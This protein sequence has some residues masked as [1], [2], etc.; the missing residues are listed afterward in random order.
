MDDLRSL[1]TLTIEE[2]MYRSSV[3][4]AGLSNTAQGD[5]AYV[6]LV[7]DSS[8]IPLVMQAIEQNDRQAQSLLGVKLTLLQNVLVIHAP[9]YSGVTL[10]R[11]AKTLQPYGSFDIA[12]KILAELSKYE[13]LHP[14]VFIQLLTPAKIY[15]DSRDMPHFQ[16]WIDELQLFETLDSTALIDLRNQRLAE[17]ML[18]AFSDDF[19]PKQIQDFALAI[20]NGAYESMLDLL[21]GL[22]AYRNAYYDSDSERRGEHIIKLV[23]KKLQRHMLLIALIV[24]G[25]AYGYYWFFYSATSVND[26]VL[27]SRIGDVQF[28]LQP[29]VPGT[30]KE[31]DTYLLDFQTPPETIQVEQDSSPIQ[32]NEVQDTHNEKT[33]SVLISPGDTLY[34]ICEQYYGDGNYYVDLAAYNNIS[35]PDI[36][37]IGIR[38]NIPPLDM[39]LESQ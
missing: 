15:I 33:E 2:Y 5:S 28:I 6:S 39:L 11:F 12:Q 21:E 32:R 26:T 29:D 34:S 17:L 27:K 31:P 38:L 8:K 30:M 35:N 16:F 13:V 4:L 1:D 23:W 36:I 19:V 25:L 22:S 7:R 37:P 10:S 9:A 24:I 14:S 18:S 20:E 3:L